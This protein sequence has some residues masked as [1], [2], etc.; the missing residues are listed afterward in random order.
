M[1]PPTA[2][3]NPVPSRFPVVNARKREDANASCL[4]KIN[5]SIK[6]NRVHPADFVS[7]TPPLWSQRHQGP[8]DSHFRSIHILVQ[9]KNLLLRILLINMAPV[10]DF[11]V[12]EK[13]KYLD[14][15]GSYHQS[16]H[17]FLRNE[18][19]LLTLL[20][21]RSNP[22]SHPTCQQ[23]PP[24]PCLWASNRTH[25][26]QLLHSPQRPQPPNMDVSCYILPRP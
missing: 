19:V 13:Y 22:R 21:I 8:S 26:W 23:H 25:L 20:Q 5:Q 2:V 9:P 6:L 16:V 14:G 3:C 17:P 11:A 24:K 18:S 4:L 15:F 12:K 7:Q 10:T 1:N